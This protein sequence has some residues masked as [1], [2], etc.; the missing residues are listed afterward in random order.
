MLPHGHG[1]A[2][3][4]GSLLRRP[5]RPSGR[6]RFALGWLILLLFMVQVVSGVLLSFYYQPSAAMAS[7]S[8]RYIMRDVDWGWLIRG[9]HHWAS[10]GMIALGLLQLVRVFLTGAYRGARA[11]SWWLGLL[12]LGM[13]LAFAFTGSLLLW[14]QGAYWTWHAAMQKVASVPVIGV[15]LASA[16]SGGTETSTTTPGRI[17]ATHVLLLPW[18]TF[19][20]V[21]LNVWI[22]AHSR[23][24][25]GDP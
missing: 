16:L 20:L 10:V 8:V 19:F 23:G 24:N 13:V 14:D 22:L 15:S 2:H 7:E 12:L 9:M 25:R 6:S 18:L 1:L 17:Y 4:L 21:L 5:V 11:S 3:A